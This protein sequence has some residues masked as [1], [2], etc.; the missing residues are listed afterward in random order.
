MTTFVH[1]MNSSVE[2]LTQCDDTGCASGFSSGTFE[3]LSDFLR[4]PEDSYAKTCFALT[5]YVKLE[6]SM[7][8]NCPASLTSATG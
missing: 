8:E 1:P 5:R 7:T 4:L 2:S 3:V 6:L